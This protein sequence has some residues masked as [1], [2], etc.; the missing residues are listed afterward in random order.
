M[1]GTVG[2]ELALRV[3]EVCVLSVYVLTGL[4]CICVVLAKRVQHG[5][6]MVFFYTF[7]CS[8]LS[9]RSY[10]HLYIGFLCSDCFRC[11]T[12]VEVCVRI[13]NS[14]LVSVNLT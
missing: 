7:E 14:M 6:T 8:F 1:K 10:A 5:R 13:T 3:I 11:E 2:T 4:H 12:A 9:Y